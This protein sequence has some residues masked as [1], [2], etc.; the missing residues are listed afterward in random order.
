M[1]GKHQGAF[2]P[3][4]IGVVTGFEWNERTTKAYAEGRTLNVT[5]YHPAGSDASLAH[6]AGAANWADPTA[7][8]ETALV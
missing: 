1:A 7:Q 8:F 6:D 2:E 5:N 4:G 3:P